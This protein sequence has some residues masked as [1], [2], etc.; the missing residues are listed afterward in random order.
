MTPDRYVRRLI[1]CE[2]RIYTEGLL[3]F[4]ICP[5]SVHNHPFQYF[6]EAVAPSIP[7][8]HVPRLSNTPRLSSEAH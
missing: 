3:L 2:G 5:W 8:F 7:T 6:A 4:V 1:S